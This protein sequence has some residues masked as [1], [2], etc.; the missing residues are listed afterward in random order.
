MKHLFVTFAIF[1]S[2]VLS[3]FN[4]E[5]ANASF[6]SKLTAKILPTKPIWGQVLVTPTPG[7]ICTGLGQT[8]VLSSQVQAA[9]D[10]LKGAING[11]NNIERA[12]SV[13]TGLYNML[14]TY[15]T[16]PL[17]KP[18]LGGYVLGLNFAIPNLSLCKIGS[19]PIPVF[20][21]TDTFGVSGGLKTL[22]PK[23]SDLKLNAQNLITSPGGTTETTNIVD[24]VPV[25]TI[26][27]NLITK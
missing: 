12:S 19:I 5:V 16:D 23:W 22:T 1:I 7:I 20:K 21:T 3:I 4:F 24:G 13:I 10:T 14:P 25:T 9:Q 8:M 15:G 11:S 6:T 27:K 17:K 2:L 26:T 18:T